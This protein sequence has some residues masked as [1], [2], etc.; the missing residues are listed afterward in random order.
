MKLGSMRLLIVSLALAGSGAFSSLRAQDA[1]VAPSS[2]VDQCVKWMKATVPLQARDDLDPAGFCSGT[3]K[4]PIGGWYSIQHCGQPLEQLTG[5][6]SRYCTSS[7]Q[8]NP[9]EAWAAGFSS[10]TKYGSDLLDGASDSAEGSRRNAATFYSRTAVWVENLRVPAGMYIL[11]PSKSPD[12]WS[13]T[14]AKRDRDWSEAEPKPQYL[15]SVKMKSAAAD[16]PTGKPN[17]LVSTS[18]WA[19]GCPGPAPD[20]NVR[21]LHFVYGSTDL[22]V[23]IRP[24]QVLQNQEAN[25]SER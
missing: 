7:G 25:I 5:A 13:L 16:N 4:G 14:V 3:Y 15:G 10:P 17:L 19:E 11:I 24:D 22:F 21:E 9:R 2:E 23:C 18:P 20:F 6:P 8:I 12:G 1:P